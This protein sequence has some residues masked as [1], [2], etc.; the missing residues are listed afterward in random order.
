[1]PLIAM[2]P[3]SLNSPRPICATCTSA[4]H[5]VVAQNEGIFSQVKT[6]FAKLFD[7]SAWPPRWHCGTWSDFHGW[8]YIVSDVLIW[9]AYFAIPFL[10]FR[11]INKR[12]DIPFP[13]IIWLFI[14]FILLCGTTHLIDALIFWLPVYRLSALVRF[15][16][17]IVS[18]FT[19]FALYKILPLIYRL[20]TLDDLEAEIEERKKAEQDARQHQ[21]MQEAAEELMAKK[22]EFM[23][24]ASHELKTPITSLKASLQVVERMVTKNEALLPVLPFAEKASKQTTK[25]TSLVNQLLDVTRIQAGRLELNRVDF[26]L[27]DM[28]NITVEQCQNSEVKHTVKVNCDNDIVI[29]A[30]KERL[31]QVLCNLL[32]NAFKYSPL[33]T[34]VLLEVQKIDNGKV[35]LIVTDYGI[36]IPADK[37]EHIFDRFYRVENTSQNFSGMGLGLY[38]SSQIIK[39]H[40]GD[41]GVTSTEGK[42]S[43]FWFAI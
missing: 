10:L 25:L 43:T 17:G 9:G 12:K 33:S 18:V 35:K 14:A 39:Q 36:G 3:K 15:L 23:S 19:V 27:L 21:I 31:D 24:I 40:G 22:D 2:S 28:I 42:G 41:I 8:L 30:D 7:T 13:K 1:L 11:I 4:K 38:I 16:T 34:E 26:N 37:A 20:R 5:I 6:F 32:T 29:N